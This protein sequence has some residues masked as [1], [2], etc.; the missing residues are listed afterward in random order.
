MAHDDSTSEESN[1]S[2]ETHEFSK[3]ISQ[4]TVEE[5]EA[6]FLDGVLI[7]GFIHLKEIA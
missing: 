5:N 6:G 2:R 1:D 7:D 4:V 3:E